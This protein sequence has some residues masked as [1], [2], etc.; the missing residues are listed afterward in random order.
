MIRQTV[1]RPGVTLMEVLIAIGI[2]SIG[3][4]AILALF[5]IG[6]VSMARAINQNRAADQA[7]AS[8]AMFRFYW[9]KAWLD[10]NGGGVRT[11]GWEAG[12][13][14]GED[15]IWMLDHNSPVPMWQA[16]AALSYG[17]GDIPM[18]SSQPS[19]V[20]CVDPVGC[21]TQTGASQFYVGGLASMPKR[22][23]LAVAKADPL[24]RTTIRVTTL[25]DDLSWDVSGEPSAQAGQLDRGGRYNVSWLI[26]RPKNNVPHEVRLFV[27]VY[28]G[29][30]PTDTPSLETLY[31]GAVSNYI[32]NVDPKPNSI[33][34]QNVQSMPNIRRGSWVGMTMPVMPQTTPP[35]PQAIPYQVLDFYRVAGVTD[36]IANTQTIT[37]ELEEPLRTYDV[38]S[39]VPLAGYNNGNFACSVIFFDNLLEVFDR[40]IVS[41]QGISGR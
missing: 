8:D 12:L 29:R 11:T 20:V 19:F 18:N 31:P 33:T 13:A 16:S 10:P 23:S 39:L 28:G 30:S 9:K 4:L 32:P 24:P 3:M 2:L 25:L 5:P 15:S 21:R 6:A 35:A 38:N 34:V 17:P 14:S 26:Q 41:A 37:L 36:D 1:R 40:G 22:S 27:M 7:A